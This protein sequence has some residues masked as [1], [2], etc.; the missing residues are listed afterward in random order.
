MR[1]RP[2]SP[3]GARLGLRSALGGLALLVLTLAPATPARSD[4]WEERVEPGHCPCE[5]G[6]ACWH[7]LRAPMRPPED[8][9][10]CGVC[11]AGGD[12]SGR[13]R[14]KGTSAACWGSAKEECFLKRHAWSWKIRCSECWKDTECDACDEDLGVADPKVRKLLE[15]QVTLETGGRRE[16]VVVA[17]TPH[18]YVVTNIESMK[19]RTQPSGVRLMRTHELAHLYAQRCEQAYEDFVHW[20]GPR[21]SLGKPMGVYLMEKKSD[22]ERVSAAYFGTPRTHQMYG[23]GGNRIGGGIAGNGFVGSMQEHGRDDRTMHG[24]VR[25]QIGNV[26]FSCWIVVS[27]DEK[28]CP[29]WAF[30][31]AGHFLSK[32]LPIHD[33]Y[34]H[35]CSDEGSAPSGSGK[36]WDK[37]A[38]ALS[39]SRLIPIQTFF[40]KDSL[41]QFEYDDH[42]RAWSYMDLALREDRERWLAALT[43]IR[44]GADEGVAFKEGMGITPEEFQER[45]KD[46]LGGRRPTL[47]EIRRDAR[48]DE[49]PGTRE[50]RRIGEETD[51]Q[52]LAGLVR[53]L[54]VVKDPKMA[55]AVIA[56]LDSPSDLVRESIH[57]VLARTQV[58]EVRAVLRGD[59]LAHAAP[60]VRAGVA[61]ALGAMKDADSREALEA[62]LKDSHWRVRADAAH[63]LQQL[64][65]PASFPVLVAAM[66]ERNE[67]AWISVCDAVS[68]YGKRSE[69]ATSAAAERLGANE[70]QLRLTACRGLA[71]FGT[72]AAMDPLIDRFD[73]EGGRLSRELRAALKA[74]SHD[75]L[76]PNASTWRRWWDEQK[77]SAGGLPPLPEPA[78]ADPDDRYAPSKPTGQDEPHY[79]GKR[80]FSKSVSFVLDTSLSMNTSISVPPEAAKRLGDI[81]TSAPR[82]IVAKEA[83]ISALRALDPRTRFHLVFFSSDVRPWKDQMVVASP[84]NVESAVSTIRNAPADGE[85]NIHG[86]L[87]AALGMTEGS[88]LD[89]SLDP[90]PDTVFFLTDGSPTRGEITSAPELLSWFADVNRFAKVELNVIALG[91]LGVDLPFLSAL[92]ES[93]GGEFLHVPER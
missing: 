10:R 81:P 31:G 64:A 22:Q 85:T 27:G 17:I 57:L 20:F 25:H 16:R 43:A 11:I 12:C 45:W 6:Q 5:G 40:G 48:P 19:L 36:D 47:G 88:A 79:Y 58:P 61:R 93:G 83:L 41:G 91:N 63:A 33:D 37:K 53:G 69:P 86:A 72:P 74:V 89:A 49:D 38:R 82:F 39:A 87:R 4:A 14:P 13:A 60:L 73:V 67:K 24:Y 84:P 18:F 71:R 1:I 32:L 54:D 9:C 90:I 52:V 8:P 2:F 59:G 76:G 70:W 34:V 92:A 21:V 26:L 78:P 80:I 51:P 42:I 68:S 50:R 62:A 29:K 35:Y 46:R 44:H 7:Y 23:G 65:D 28:V 77:R 55:R 15:D 56:R 30:E 66:G 3:L 75:D